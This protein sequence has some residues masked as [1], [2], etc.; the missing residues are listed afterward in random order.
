MHR[1]IAY[2]IL[3]MVLIVAITGAIITVAPP[4]TPAG[5]QVIGTGGTDTVT[6]TPEPT[7]VDGYWCR[8]SYCSKYETITYTAQGWTRDYAFRAFK[9]ACPE[10]P[11]SQITVT[12]PK[13]PRPGETVVSVAKCTAIGPCKRCAERRAVFGSGFTQ[14]EAYADCKKNAPSG[15]GDVKTEACEKVPMMPPTPAV[16]LFKGT[17]TFENIQPPAGIKFQLFDYQLIN[18]VGAGE[19]T[20]PAID[21][22]YK[23]SLTYQPDVL[24]FSVQLKYQPDPFQPG[25]LRRL[26]CT[27][28]SAGVVPLDT[29]APKGQYSAPM[30]C[31][32]KTTA[33]ATITDVASS[34]TSTDRTITDIT[35]PTDC[36]YPCSLNGAQCIAGKLAG[37]CQNNCCLTL[38]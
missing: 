23:L 24:P 20:T 34:T 8:C 28:N 16:T 3:S 29:S 6:I 15:S 19:T 26:E 13:P 36:P 10:T 31:G 1:S 21:G 17:T 11:D 30:T 7:P 4:Q 5:N 14:E 32:E 27:F 38:V 9:L 37:Y 22:N 18:P 2:N 12:C 33:T 35:A 25:T